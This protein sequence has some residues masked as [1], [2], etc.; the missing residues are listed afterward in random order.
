ML[1][2]AAKV[3]FVTLVA[4]ITTTTGL[5]S[6]G[7]AQTAA[8]S[9]LASASAADDDTAPLGQFRLRSFGATDGL[10]NL[11][12]L[13]IVQDGDGMLWVAT[14]DG[15]YRYDGQLFMH[16]SMQDG[17]PAMGVRVLGVA[18]DGAVCAGTRDGM[19]CWNGSRFTPAGAAGLPATWIQALAAGPGV[20]WAGTSAGLFVR[21]G[22]AAFV[23]APGW[24]ASP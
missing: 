22:S 1:S 12:V 4:L 8:S 11:I 15:V 19:A 16:Y 17:L 3:G 23:P 9:E 21:R 24:P 14:D 5:A 18:P 7:G 10:R 13:G 6:P 20:L 2:R